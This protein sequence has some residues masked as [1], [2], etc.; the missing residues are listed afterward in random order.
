[1]IVGIAVETEI[2][3]SSCPP[4]RWPENCDF[5]DK[6]IVSQFFPFYCLLYV[7][8][9]F[10]AG[11]IKKRDKRRAGLCLLLFV[12]SHKKINEVPN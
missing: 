1:M 10:Q 7:S 3:K 8:I 12:E 5:Q 9:P 4:Q 11:K 2:R 6:Y